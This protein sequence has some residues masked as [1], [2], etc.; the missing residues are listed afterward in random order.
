MRLHWHRR[1]LRV[2]DNRGLAAVDDRTLPVFVLDPGV[3]NHAAPPRVSFLLD[4]LDSLRAAYRE[5]GGDLLI[6]EGDPVERLPALAADRGA[7]TVT[8][9]RD[10]SGLARERDTAVRRALDADVEAVHDAVHHEPGSITTNDGDPYAV[11]TY[12]SK[13]WHD[14]PKAEPYE[15]PASDSLV[16]IDD[17]AAGTGPVPAL[18]DLGFE[19]PEA[20]LPPAGTDAARD[21]LQSFCEADIYR[22][23]E[24]RDYPADRCT[25][26]LSPHLK[27]GTI[28]IR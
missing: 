18:A 23:G 28:G 26:R 1:D 4:A 22:Y 6:V 11:F 2:A 7:E 20:E 24:R 25:S 5:R 10:Y 27:Y 21:R 19:E 9:C 12:F 13:K 14:R 16:S 17:E 3:L 8:W 15:P